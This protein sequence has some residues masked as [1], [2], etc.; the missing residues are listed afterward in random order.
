MWNFSTAYWTKEYLDGDYL[1]TKNQEA[2]MRVLQQIWSFS[3]EEQVVA[4]KSFSAVLDG[5]HFSCDIFASA[6]VN[7]V[8]FLLANA[9]D[10]S[11]L[12]KAECIATWFFAILDLNRTRYSAYIQHWRSKIISIQFELKKHEVNKDLSRILSELGDDIKA[13]HIQRGWSL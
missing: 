6:V 8:N 4:A 13:P 11:V 12:K 7:H 2:L 9:H 10:L 1:S 5:P 3:E